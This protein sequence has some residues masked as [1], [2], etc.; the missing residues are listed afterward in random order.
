MQIFLDGLDVLPQYVGSLALLLITAFGL[1]IWLAALLP[2]LRHRPAALRIPLAVCMGTGALVVLAFGVSLA[3]RAWPVALLPGYLLLAAAGCLGAL[4]WLLVTRRTSFH[5]GR[6]ALPLGAI[7]LLLVLMLR[8]AFLKGLLLPPNFDSPQHYL[9]VQDILSPDR[10]PRALYSL[11]TILRKYYHFGFH[12]LAAWLVRTTA[13]RPEMSLALLGQAFL[14]LLPFSVLCLGW[15]MTDSLP[16]ALAAALLA[17]LGWRLPAFAA[18]WGKYPALAGIALLPATLAVLYLGGKDILRRLPVALAAGLMVLAQALLHSRILVC[19]ALAL[20][21]YALACLLMRGRRMPVWLALLLTAIAAFLFAVRSGPLWEVFADGYYVSLGVLFLLLPF[22]LR[23]YPRLALAA[24][25]TLAG[26][27]LVSLLPLPPGLRSYTF[28]WLDAPFLETVA[29]LPLALLGGLGLAGLLA[30]LN[31]PWLR[32][33]VGALFILIILGNA[34]VTQSFVP[35]PCCNVTSPADFQALAWIGQST[36]PDA[37]VVIA[38]AVSTNGEFRNFST[39]TDAGAWV[40]ALT[41]RA[42][43]IE[44]YSL[45]WG[46]AAAR[47]ML[48]THKAAYVYAGDTQ[49]SFDRKGL[50]RLGWLQPVLGVSPVQLYQVTGCSGGGWHQ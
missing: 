11:Q 36:S 6:A 41:G 8:L 39:A 50:A 48:C 1:G 5:P 25:F 33:A 19:L 21:G 35:D 13:I 26:M 9:I 46:S 43:R 18:N 10:A 14:V 37:L 16:A 2:G 40:T 47:Q 34:L 30:V 45:D 44:P 42:S 15:T 23:I 27:L 38:G 17:C 49:F 29:S 4:T 20:V 22:A 28:A 3:A 24:L 12:S 32:L 7:L 31:R